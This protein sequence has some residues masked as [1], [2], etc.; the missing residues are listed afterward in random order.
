MVTLRN[1]TT[2]FVVE[3]GQE[4]GGIPVCTGGLPVS[5]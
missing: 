5:V 3:P 1:R 2:P 4:M